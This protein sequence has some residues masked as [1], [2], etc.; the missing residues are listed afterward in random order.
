MHSATTILGCAALHLV[1]VLVLLGDIGQLPAVQLLQEG[2]SCRL[3]H[4]VLVRFLRFCVGCHHQLRIHTKRLH[5]PVLPHSQRT[6]LHYCSTVVDDEANEVLPP[7][8]SVVLV[9][10]T[11]RTS[12]SWQV[13][14]WVCLIR[15]QITLVICLI[16][17]WLKSRWIHVGL[18]LGWW[19][20][21]CLPIHGVSSCTGAPFEGP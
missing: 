9:W 15:S 6:C 18:T 16:R 12:C 4:G 19:T 1:L 3:S 8:W 20:G 17:N 21:V 7:V 2:S 10:W 14:T 5:Q 13:N 11:Y